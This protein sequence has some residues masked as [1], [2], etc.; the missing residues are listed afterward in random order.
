MAD[1][2]QGPGV[3]AA[4]GKLYAVG[5]FGSGP[6]SGEPVN[7]LL[8]SAEVFDPAAG[9]WACIAAAP[10]ARSHLALVAAKGGLAALGGWGE[11][12]GLR[13]VEMYH[14]DI[15]TWFAG[16]TMPSRHG[17]TAAVATMAPEPFGA[18]HS[19]VF[20]PPSSVA[21]SVAAASAPLLASVG[22]GASGALVCFHPASGGA[23][24]CCGLGF[25]GLELEN[26]EQ[27]LQAGQ[28]AAVGPPTGSSA[29]AL[30]A[31]AE[32]SAAATARGVVCYRDAAA[33]PAGYCRALS[34]DT[35]TGATSAGPPAR[36][37]PAY[38]V[39]DAETWVGAGAV[40]CPQDPTEPFCSPDPSIAHPLDGSANSGMTR[41]CPRPSTLQ[42]HSAALPVPLSTAPIPWQASR[43]TSCA[44]CAGC[45]LPTCPPA[46]ATP[47][48]SWRSATP[49]SPARR[50]LPS[51]IAP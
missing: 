20:H 24:T 2:R 43:R 13:L 51:P 15:D 23:F 27:A 34:T 46:R 31:M 49:G 21:T 41:L 33:S 28:C 18:D 1:T 10:T 12:G 9:S 19:L 16:P 50:W 4:D 42:Q 37:T 17:Y 39:G 45:A 25:Q 14:P 26:L 22:G 7:T 8:S 5:G 40:A 48:N 11:A 47:A 32:D 6:C 3:A 38:C 29:E 30:L 36:V 44:L 35:A